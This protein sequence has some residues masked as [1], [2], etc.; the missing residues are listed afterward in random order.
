MSA[1]PNLMLTAAATASSTKLRWAVTVAT[2]TKLYMQETKDFAKLK[3]FCQTNQNHSHKKKKTNLISCERVAAR[4]TTVAI[5]YQF[6]TIE[7]HFVRKSCRG[8]AQIAIL[9]RFLTITPHFVQRGVHLVAPRQHRPRP[10][11]KRK[12]G[13]RARERASEGE[14]E[15]ERER[16]RDGQ[17]ER[18]RKKER[19]RVRRCEDA[20]CE[21]TKIR[22]CEDAVEMST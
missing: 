8:S 1:Q 17:R 13:E 14:E 15:G 19:E 7:P 16:E 10:R 18:E 22:R 4:P 20:R 11:E 5:I 21:D 3:E 9:H 6:W 12:E 2:W